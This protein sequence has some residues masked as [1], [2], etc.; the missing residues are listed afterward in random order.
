M[1]HSASPARRLELTVI[2]GTLTAF[3]PLSIDM[4]LPAFPAIGEALGADAAGVQ[5]TLSAFF[6]AFALGQLLYGPLADSLGRKPPLYGGLVLFV[7][8]SVACAVAPTVGLLATARFV[9][10][11]GACAGVVVAR[12]IVRDLFEADDAARMFSALMLVTG[13]APMLAPLA[14]GQLLIHLGWASI[15]WTLGGCGAAVALATLFRLP[16][17]GV[18]KPRGTITPLGALATYRRLLGDPYFLVPALTGGAGMAGLFAY[19][20]GSPFV[21]IELMGVSPQTYGLI[22]GSCALGMVIAA[23]VN[24]RLIGRFGMERLLRW[25]AHFQLAFGLMVAAFAAS[26]S[27]SLAGLIVPLFFYV[28]AVGFVL[29]NNMALTMAPYAANAGSAAAL[30]GALQFAL[31]AIASAAMGASDADSALP[32]ALILAAFAAL[33]TVLSRI[34]AGL[35]R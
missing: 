20:S 8:A 10:G 30:I 4:Y 23:Q 21:L 9:Q 35:R 1:Y 22:F 19:I 3:A 18:R 17:T 2:L 14:G 32:M 7:L 25:G 15:F 5:W 13:L 24:R 16:E 28:A 11:L 12:A 26:G 29:P 6:V 34:S 33:C 27:S 31:G